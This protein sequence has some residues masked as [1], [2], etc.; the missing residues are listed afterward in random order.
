MSTPTR[1]A[2]ASL[3]EPSRARPQAKW[4]RGSPPGPVAARARHLTDLLLR[5]QQGERDAFVEAIRVSGPYL[6]ARLKSCEHTRAIGED[7]EDALQDATV[8]AW[9]FLASYRAD[10]GS[11]AGWLW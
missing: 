9:K 2:K 5:A 10:R 1:R 3:P 7:L 4:P 11:A 8:H 6:I